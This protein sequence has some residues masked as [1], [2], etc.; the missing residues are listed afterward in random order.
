MQL[1]VIYLSN[2]GQKEMKAIITGTTYDLQYNFNVFR[3]RKKI[4]SGWALS[5]NV[6]NIMFTKGSNKS[7]M[8]W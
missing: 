2:M 5:G 1:P 3:I 8:I 6:K 7:S 4:Q